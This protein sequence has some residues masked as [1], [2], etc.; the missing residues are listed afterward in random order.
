V[1]AADSDFFNDDLTV[2]SQLSFVKGIV[3]PKASFDSPTDTWRRHLGR[4]VSLIALLESPKAILRAS[5]VAQ[6]GFDRLALGPVDLAAC[7]ATPTS[8]DLMWYPRSMLVFA[9]AAFG[10]EPPVDGPSLSVSDAVA[11]AE[12]SQIARR[13]GMGGKL[14]IHPFQVPIVNEA[15]KSDNDIAWA[16]DVLE[17]AKKHDGNAFVWQGKMVDS[18]VLLHARR[19]LGP[20][21]SGQ[22]PA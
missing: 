7:L 22:E 3:V 10:L 4:G 5:D 9:S 16:Q 12:E 1:N 6:S 20:S 11:V 14:C 18:A 17:E 2:V 21:S 15:F 19:L 13:L 8:D